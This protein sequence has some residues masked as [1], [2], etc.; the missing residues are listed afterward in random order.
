MQ[1]PA[2]RGRMTAI[3]AVRRLI[4][5]KTLVVTTTPSG[6]LVIRSSGARTKNRQEGDDSHRKPVAQTTPAQE[7]T[8]IVVTGYRVGETAGGTRIMTAVK[9]LPMSVEIVNRELI[10][11]LGARKIEDAIRYVSGINKVNRNDNL[12]RGERFAIRGFNSSL[13]MRNGVPYNVF[14]DTANIQ[15]IDVVKGANSILYGFNDPGGLINFI[16]KAPQDKPGYSVSQTVG[17][18]RYYRTEAD[19]TGPLFGDTNYRLVGAYTNSGSWL[20]NGK[21]ETIFV[22][23]VVDIGLTDNTR[24]VL[25]YEYRRQNSRGLREGYPLL[26]DAK[27]VAYAY[28]DLGSRYS[29]IFPQ[30]RNINKVQNFEARLTHSF[31]P[32]TVLRLVAA[33]TDIRA[34]Q[35]NAFSGNILP[36]SL[37]QTRTRV[38]LEQNRQKTDFLFADFSTQFSFLGM[39]HKVILGGQH[40]ERSGQ[41]YGR[42]SDY[43][44]VWNIRTNDYAVHYA[45]PATRA[46]MMKNVRLTDTAPTK[47]SGVYIIDQISLLDDRLHVLAGG[48]Y[49][50]LNGV[51]RFTPQIGGNVRLNDWLSAYALYSESFR[52]NAPYTYLDTGE[53]VTFPPE[54]GQNREFGFK[55]DLFGHRLSSTLAFFSLKRTNVL[56]A[57][58]SQ[59]PLRPHLNLSGGERSRGVEF[60]VS[61][62]ISRSLS[63][64]GSYAYTDTKVLSSSNAAT[65]GAPLEGVAKNAASLFAK[66]DLGDVGPG[67]LSL[68]AGT[69]WREG[70]IL[71]LN[72]IPANS[73]IHQDSY[74]VFDGGIDYELP[75]R[76]TFSIKSTNIGNKAYMD[77]RSAYAAPREVFFTIRK[78]F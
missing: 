53:V 22:N 31:T 29:P 41:G 50:R 52:L 5:G 40:L 18:Y 51:G 59:D 8:D 61:G 23:P 30:N 63:I 64:F 17:T 21:D 49:D 69:L 11:D 2:L 16:T 33:H 24:L 48:R 67:R 10:E 26:F 47:S 54:V 28:P 46:D 70:P 7:G 19:L 78:A 55:F 3:N 1:A 45:I 34:D 37:T 36:G 57:T 38:Y 9:D 20:A 66:Y 71:L 77:R 44:P 32:T 62:K 4:A 27:N 58:A 15:Q 68:N 60:D 73:L 72:N 75:G 14:S 65:V 56:Q 74:I 25:D 12:A 43:G 6:S 39:Q 76:L 42:F 13:I 35:F